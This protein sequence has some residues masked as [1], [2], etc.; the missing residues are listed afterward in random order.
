KLGDLIDEGNSDAAD[1]VAEIRALLTSS[2]VADDIRDLE[3]Q[4]NDYEFEEARK[5]FNRITRELSVEV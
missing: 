1:L 4:I 5:L 2:R 3:F